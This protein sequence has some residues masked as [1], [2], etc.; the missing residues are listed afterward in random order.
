MSKHVDL[1]SLAAG[2]SPS[3]EEQDHLSGCGECRSLLEDLRDFDKFVAGTQPM[4][5]DGWERLEATK[6]RLETE[7]AA[8]GHGETLRTLGLVHHFLDQAERCRDEEPLRGLRLA[9][10]AAAI[11]EELRP[12]AD[13]PA[14][15]ILQARGEAAKE[16]A[17]CLR[18]LGRFPE[19]HE[20]IAL[21]LAAFDEMTCGH[22]DTACA[23][24]VRATIKAAQ[25]DHAGARADAT[26]AAGELAE[27][28]ETVRTSHAK[29][30]IAFTYAQE[31]RYAEAHATLSASL[32]VLDQ[33]AEPRA[34]ATIRLNLADC[35]AELG[36]LSEAREH[37]AAAQQYFQGNPIT[38]ARIRWQF[39]S[40]AIR[41]LRWDEG[42]ALLQDAIR[43]F[44]DQE[45]PLETA[46][47]SLELTEV[48]LA[49]GQTAN[50]RALCE[51]LP[52]QCEAMGLAKNLLVALAYLQEVE[53][54]EAKVIR[55][56]RKFLATAAPEQA[57]LP[58]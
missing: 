10:R 54:Q 48:L 56:V 17:N 19:A 18:I 29:N 27:F 4:V 3:A 51:A 30:L 52:Q 13:Q 36:R 37:L 16:R 41:E 55:T 9:E 11:V 33:E 53:H 34:V 2:R 40:L 24:Y 46:L 28:G 43:A 45:L 22:F 7:R 14:T 42:I 25:E 47:A 58:R 32:Q 35:C 8:A 23:L 21:A 44:R 49:T 57:F 38:S 15:M 20:A 31:G 5:D 12:A 39:G 26:T 1:E 6:K 50:A